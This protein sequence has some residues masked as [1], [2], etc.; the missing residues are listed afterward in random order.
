MDM[1][2]GIFF[3]VL[4][5]VLFSLIVIA[6]GED[7]NSYEKDVEKWQKGIDEHVPID[8]E[9]GE[10]DPSKYKSSAEERIA[11]INEWL[12]NN[13][14]WLKVV[15]GMVPEVSWLF[16]FNIYLWMFF[17]VNLVLNGNIF[18]IALGGLLKKWRRVLGLAIF[19]AMLVTKIIYSLALFS[20]KTWD[21]ILNKL[22]PIGIMAVFIG[23]AII[24]I[25]LIVLFIVAPQILFS[26]AKWAQAKRETK[27]KEAESVNREAL[28]ALTENL[29]K[30]TS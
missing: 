10:F 12:E 15:F 14:S 2:R 3:L 5:V 30:R 11:K 20:Y 8:P 17:F 7:D 6:N 18:D 1:K 28:G 9:T 16:G 21:I 27:E 13:A 24:I 25:L 26:L 4:G 23:G 19:V 22:I 29:I